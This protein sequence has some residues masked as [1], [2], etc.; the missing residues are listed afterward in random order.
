MKYKFK[1]TL[2]HFIFTKTYQT[3]ARPQEGAP[4]ASYPIVSVWVFDKHACSEAQVRAG[5]SKVTCSTLI[6]IL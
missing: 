2:V 3:K 1:K 4:T 5:L 6:C